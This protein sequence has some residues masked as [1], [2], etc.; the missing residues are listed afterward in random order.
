MLVSAKLLDELYG[1]LKREKF[2][3]YVTLDQVISYMEVI[4]ASSVL[5][6]D[7]PMPAVQITPDR[8]DDYIILLAQSANAHVVVSGDSHLEGFIHDSV[9]VVRPIE[10]LAMI[11]R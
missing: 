8:G 6:E 11:G 4:R 7:P 10:F 1:V 5:V 2:R 3:R 9:Q